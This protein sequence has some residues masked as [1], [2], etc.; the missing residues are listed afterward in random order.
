MRSSLC[1]G[2][3]EENV[4]NT[5]QRRERISVCG[6]IGVRK[7]TNTKKKFFIY[8]RKPVWETQGVSFYQKANG[9]GNLIPN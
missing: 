5:A 2:L 1:S 8:A 6:F 9:V 3:D 7:K 4:R